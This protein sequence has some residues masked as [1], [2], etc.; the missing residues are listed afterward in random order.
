LARKERYNLFGA[1]VL[2]TLP[3]I[4]G[5]VLRDL[6]LGVDQVFVLVTPAYFLVAIFVVISGFG[7]I[8]CY[9]FM[10]DRS[11]VLAHTISSFIEQKLGG[12]FNRLFKFF[13]AWAVASFTVI[14]VSV[15]LEMR[16]EPIWLWGPAMA[17]LTA[18]GGVILRDIV[19]A[20]FNIEMLKQ[21][22][23]AE[24][25][26][27][28]GIIYTCALM[29]Y[30]FD[31][32]LGLIFY[33]TMSMVLLLFGL[34]FFILWKGYLN[35][36]QFGDI[37]THPDTRLQHFLDK[38]PDL[39]KIVAGYYMEDNQFKTAPVSRSKLEELHNQF[40]YLTGELKDSL[41]KVAAEPLNEKT[42]NNYRQCNARLEIALS[43]ENN[44]FAFLE[45]RPGAG[46]QI[47][48]NGSELQQLMHEGLRTMIDTT[49]M[50]IESEDHMDFKL[51]EG[52]TSQDQ[53]RFND[54]RNKYGA[55]QREEDAYLKAVLQSTHKVERIIYL[56][57]DYV[58]L[59]LDKR[60]VRAGSANNR[61]AQQVHI[62]N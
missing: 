9:D 46:L 47:S 23:Y 28:G 14:G 22:T 45:H 55:R 10:H 16:A 25:S 38:E 62:L 40:L 60:E 11:S 50:A 53:Q 5:G 49:A 19:R 51:L 27:F 12:I 20:D 37:Y 6:F 39:W 59:R 24:I 61:K 7:I 33:L 4:G 56:L 34:R 48:K 57:S 41:N 21:D 58:R 30:P 44:L 3:A 52:I 15:T 31:I 29:Y 26:I 32:S 1:L 17:V 13:D 54:L 18:S 35:P 8:I 42:I 36:F 43:L 2:A